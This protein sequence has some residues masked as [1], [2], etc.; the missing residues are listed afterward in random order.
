MLTSVVNI[1]VS[2]FTSQKYLTIHITLVF[3]GCISVCLVAQNQNK[4]AKNSFIY[5]TFFLMII[6]K[7]TTPLTTK[8]KKQTWKFHM[9]TATTFIDNLWT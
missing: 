6:H 1:Q 4:M 5:G 7:K 9:K 2:R 8:T 3:S